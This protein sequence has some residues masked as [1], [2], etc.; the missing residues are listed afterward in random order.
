MP[1]RLYSYSL[2]KIMTVGM[3]LFIAF[4]CKTKQSALAQSKVTISGTVTQTSSYCGGAQP[5]DELIT[6]LQT[7]RI[8]PGKKMHVIKGD[9][10]TAKREI[11]LDFITDEKGTFSFQLAPGTY[12]ILL[13]EQ[14]LKPNARQYET[15][16]ILVD[17]KCYNEWWGKPYYLLHVSSAPITNLSFNFQRPC[18]IDYDIPCLRYNGVMPP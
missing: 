9:T 5:T 11:V 13:D 17:E 12:S 8:F 14:I 1:T 4:S 10:N 18:F 15:K 6:E 16:D 7:P 2:M 3:F